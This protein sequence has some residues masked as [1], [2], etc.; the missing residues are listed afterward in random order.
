LQS[1]DE[2][3]SGKLQRAQIAAPLT[4]DAYRNK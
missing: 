3:V 4:F 2:T 1:R